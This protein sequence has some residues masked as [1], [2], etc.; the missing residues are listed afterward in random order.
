MCHHVEQL[1]IY[2]FT[3]D[4]VLSWLQQNLTVVQRVQRNKPKTVCHIFYKT[5]TIQTKFGL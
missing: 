2:I 5:W 3:C 4:N 1:M